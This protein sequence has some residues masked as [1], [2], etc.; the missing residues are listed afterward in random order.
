M[1]QGRFKLH[2]PE[3]THIL[4]IRI[5]DELYDLIRDEVEYDRTT[6]QNITTQILRD[7]IEIRQIA[8]LNKL[9]SEQERRATL[10]KAADL[11]GIRS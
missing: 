7:G 3:H 1:A 8:R 2:D 9:Q 6:I 4:T 11:I 5:S 10:R